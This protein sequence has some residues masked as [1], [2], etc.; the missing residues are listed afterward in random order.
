MPLTLF[1]CSLPVFRHYLG[2]LVDLLRLA[3]AHAMAHN[4]PET[5]VLEARLASDMQPFRV[6]VEI[7]ANLVLR[8]AF[9]LAGQAVPDY[10]DYPASFAGLHKRVYRV[11]QLL[12]TLDAASF[13]DD[14]ERLIA[15]DAGKANLQLPAHEFLLQFALPNFFFHIATAYGIL[16]HL[17][18]AV[19]K[20]DFDGYHSYPPLA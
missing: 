6:Q 7:A 15:F 18:V 9:P 3:E 11:S 13:D 20:G 12:E 10:G 4:W 2:R 8:A 1:N 5:T 16:R 19:G 17:G 14:G